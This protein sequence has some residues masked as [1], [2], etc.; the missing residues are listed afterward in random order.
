M[1]VLFS[2]QNF[3]LNNVF[4]YSSKETAAFDTKQDNEGKI[5]ILQLKPGSH[6]ITS[7]I[8]N[9]SFLKIFSLIELDVQIDTFSTAMFVWHTMLSGSS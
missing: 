1:K 5:Y 4:H 8:G 2:L 9:V 7:F 3:P 6:F